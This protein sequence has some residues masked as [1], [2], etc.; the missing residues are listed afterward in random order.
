MEQF[1]T[2]LQQEFLKRTSKNK[3]Y[4]LRAFAKT[5]NVSHA[6]LSSMMTG[7]RTITPGTVAR[8]SK[9]LGLSPQ[10][11]ERFLSKETD[12][13]HTGNSYYHIQQ[14]TFN[15]ISDWYYDAILQLSLI[16]RVKLEPSFISTALGIPV[17][18]SKLALETLE[19]LELLKKDK[20]S[21][22][23]KTQKNST[24]ILDLDFTNAAMKK[25]Q[26]QILEK[27][28]EALES[29]S[30]LERDHTSTTMAIQ[31][32]DLP[33]VKEIIRRFRNDLDKYLQ[34][35]DVALN[36]IYQLQVSFFP[37]SNLKMKTTSQKI[38]ETL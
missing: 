26:K 8:F 7:K 12:S 17:L 14:D 1:R 38:K 24:N 25:Y 6:T 32:E 33:K 10:D 21:T 28:L 15:F 23:R 29:V 19:R 36:E 9:F 27:S 20:N 11:V 34:R 13:N 5:L 30:K 16:P 31:K 37:L 22:Y 2:Y 4:S 35:D 3:S 18:E